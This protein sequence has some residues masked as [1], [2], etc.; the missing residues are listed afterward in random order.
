MGFDLKPSV[1]GIAWACTD[2]ERE[3]TFHQIEE[4]FAH[5]AHIGDVI[6]Y[7]RQRSIEIDMVGLIDDDICC[8]GEVLSNGAE[9]LNHAAGSDRGKGF[10]SLTMSFVFEKNA[11]AFFKRNQL[12]NTTLTTVTPAI[13]AKITADYVDAKVQICCYAVVYLISDLFSLQSAI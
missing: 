8:F 10:L 2:R 1:Y 6:H 9:Q 5:S 7:L 3:A 11:K 4:R 13:I 12:A